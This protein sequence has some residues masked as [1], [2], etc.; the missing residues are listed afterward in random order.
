MILTKNEIIK[1]I[2]KGRIKITPFESKNIGP[3]SYDLTLGNEFRDFKPGIIKVNNE[4]DFRKYTNKVIKDEIVLEPGDFILGITKEKITLPENICG[5]LGAR[6]R[7]ARIGLQIHVTAA[8]I[9]P[10]VSNKQVLELH[11]VSENTLILKAGTKIGQIV[12]ERTEGK[13]KY[14]GKFKNQLSL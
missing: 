6:S 4:T 14:K 12:F 2:K 8:F 13:S 11:N 10:G 1:E 7:F 5:W 3:A 9:Q